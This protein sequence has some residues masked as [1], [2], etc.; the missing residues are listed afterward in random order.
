MGNMTGI[1]N[2]SWASILLWVF[3]QKI[4]RF[5]PVML[6]GI[7]RRHRMHNAFKSQANSRRVVKIAEEGQL[8]VLVDSVFKMEDAIKVC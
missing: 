7:P 3:W 5:R 6:G 1:G 4:E 2:P 8:R